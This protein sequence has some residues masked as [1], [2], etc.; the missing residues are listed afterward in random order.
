MTLLPS[1]GKP[2]GS[3]PL[4]RIRRG[5]T[6][7]GRGNAGSYHRSPDAES[8]PQTTEERNE[9]GNLFSCSSGQTLRATAHQNLAAI[10]GPTRAGNYAITA[11][12][13]VDSDLHGFGIAFLG[14]RRSAGHQPPRQDYACGN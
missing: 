11:C 13:A 14:L 3:T 4:L 8:R 2:P 9:A 5:T 6:A 12:S 10:F 1:D 7:T